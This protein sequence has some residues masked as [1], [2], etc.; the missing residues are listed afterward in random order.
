MRIVVKLLGGLVVLIAILAGVGM[1][2]PREVTVERSTVID[3]PASDIY[4]LVA[5]LEANQQWSPWAGLDPD[6]RFTYNDVAQ[7]VGATMDW[8]SDS[9]DVGN[10]RMEIT[11]AVE[12]EALTVALNFGDMGGGTAFWDF[13]EAD[14]ATTT[15]WTLVADMGAGPIGRWFGLKM[16]DWVGADY[17]RGLANLKQVVE[18]G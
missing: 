6:A 15:T 2:L 8:A 16:D 1:L 3:A 10:G 13:E 12:N 5:N 7:G 4:P 18:G 17:E 9:A 11:E 14:G